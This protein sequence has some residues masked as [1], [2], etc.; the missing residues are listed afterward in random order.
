MPRVLLPTEHRGGGG[1]M[2]APAPV[3]LAASHPR[4]RVHQIPPLQVSHH[5]STD[6]D[7][8]QPHL[9]AHLQLATANPTDRTP[10]HRRNEAKQKPFMARRTKLTEG[11]PTTA[12]LHDPS[13]SCPT[14]S[15]GTGQLNLVRSCI[16][17]SNEVNVRINDRAHKKLLLLY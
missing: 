15:A 4:L 3:L 16:H 2:G 6:Q 8:Q 5:Q 12:P 9:D 7:K 11:P 1:T 14:R 17:S 13:R 10:P